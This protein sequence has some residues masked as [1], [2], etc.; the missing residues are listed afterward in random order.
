MKSIAY[1][2]FSRVSGSNENIKN[3]SFISKFSHF[4][5]KIAKKN[6]YVITPCPKPAAKINYVFNFLDEMK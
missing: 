2:K 1:N 5:L 3:V 6:I 4:L